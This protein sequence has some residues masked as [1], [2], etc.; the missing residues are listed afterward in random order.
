VRI[1]CTHEYSSALESPEH[2]CSKDRGVG[3]MGEK[4]KPSGWNLNWGKGPKAEAQSCDFCKK[5]AHRLQYVTGEKKWIC[6]ECSDRPM[7]ER[8]QMFGKLRPIGK[9][10]YEKQNDFVQKTKFES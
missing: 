1:V 6:A 2:D 9:K 7:L 3:G 5:E 8:G 10:E 4:S